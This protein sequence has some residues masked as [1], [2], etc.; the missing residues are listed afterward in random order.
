MRA[1]GEPPIGVEEA[2]K[3]LARLAH[4]DRVLLAVSGGP[5]SLALLYL[6]AEWRD[7]RLQSTPQIAIPHVSV[8]TVDHGLRAEAANEALMVAQHCAHLGLPHVTLHWQG[9]KPAR[10]VMN[11]ARTARYA[12]L[13]A[14]LQNTTLSGAT[15]TGAMAIVT[16]HHQDDQAET[17]FMRLARGGGVE[18]LAAMSADRALNRNSN[19]RLVRPLLDF[20]KSRLIATLHARDVSSS[21]DPTNDDET[22]ERTRV[23]AQLRAAQLDAAALARTARRM[24]QANEALTYAAE[25]FRDTLSLDLNRGVYA[26][27]NR[28]AFAH[29]P[30]ALRQRVLAELI[31][32]F[33]GATAAPD[34]SEIEAATA[35]LTSP[36][37]PTALTLGGTIISTT[38]TALRVWREPGRISSSNITLTDNETRIWDDRFWVGIS[39]PLGRPVEVRALGRSAYETIAAEIPEHM[40]LPAAAA[41]GVPAFYMSQRLVAVPQLDYDVKVL[42]G[43]SGTKLTC[44]PSC[45]PRP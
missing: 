19:V 17:V 27:L 23:R 1:D 11:A 4:F 31:A 34:V 43:F 8:A 45:R 3:A 44:E 10:G 16:A 2:E 26:S 12:L 18:A 39:D 38:N 40:R 28:A 5:D 29:G 21:A 15:K 35:R 6:V 32:M 30:V 14:E 22:Y 7:R 24:Q 13:E 41:H 36:S 9:D 25:K 42:L 37:S 20:P 33:G